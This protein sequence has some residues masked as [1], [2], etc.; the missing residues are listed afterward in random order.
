LEGRDK[1]FKAILNYI[2]SSRLAWDNKKTHLKTT[3][4]PPQ[5]HQT[6]RGRETY[7]ETETEIERERLLLTGFLKKIFVECMIL[8]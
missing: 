1:I 7:R 5:L 8:L 6:Q 2:T 3:L 4:M